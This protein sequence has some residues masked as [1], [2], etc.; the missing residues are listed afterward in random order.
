VHG[1]GVRADEMET[2]NPMHKDGTDKPTK[3]NIDGQSSDG[4]PSCIQM[5]VTILDAPMTPEQLEL[6]VFDENLS[7]GSFEEVR[8]RIYG[9]G[10]LRLG[11]WTYLNAM[12]WI[13]ENN[14]EVEPRQLLQLLGERWIDCAN[15][16]KYRHFILNCS[17]HPVLTCGP[18]YPS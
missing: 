5:P 10:Q 14:S 6:A 9:D 1:S 2:M 3:Q 13:Y 4:N 12:E 18:R 7:E 17:K 15:I 11:R 8:N 16:G